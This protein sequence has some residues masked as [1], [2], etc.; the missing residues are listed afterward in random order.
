[1][2]LWVL[3]DQVKAHYLIFYQVKE[4]TMFLVKFCLRT[5]TFLILKLRKE[6]IRE[7]F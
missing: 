4:A 2:Q 3:T 5:I 6:H 1:M 7:Y